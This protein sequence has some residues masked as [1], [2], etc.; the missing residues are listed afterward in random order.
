MVLY[1]TEIDDDITSTMLHNKVSKVDNVEYQGILNDYRT[2]RNN[3][4]ALFVVDDD[5]IL[6]FKLMFPIS[7][8]VKPKGVSDEVSKYYINC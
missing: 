1:F 4:L 3:R 2:E 7:T 5:V 6:K 8:M